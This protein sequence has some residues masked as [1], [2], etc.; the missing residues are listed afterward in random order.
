MKFP[1][2]DGKIISVKENQ[3]TARQCYAESQKISSTGQ[4]GKKDPPTVAHITHAEI[5]D[6]DLRSDSHDER[7]SPIDELDD[8][9]IGKLP[10][11][12]TK[13]SRQLNPN[14]RQQL[15][16]EILQNADLFAWSSADMP[17]IDANFICHRLAI[18]KEAK[19]VAQRK[20][21]V[22]G[23]RRE[24]IGSETQKLL[25]A[26]FICE[27]RYTTWLANVVLV[28]KNSGKWRMCIDYTDLN[29]AC[30]KDSYP[31]PSIDR[32]RLM[33]KVFHQ[34]IGRNME[35]YVDDMVV[36]TTSATDHASDLAEIFAQIRRHNMCLNLEK[37][38][39]G[40]QGGKF[41]GFMITN[42]GIETNPEKCKVIIQM[43]S[44]QTVK[45]VQRLAGR[46]VSQFGI[47]H[48]LV[49]NNGRQFIAQEFEDFL[50][51]LGIKHLPTSVEHPQTNGQAEAANKVIL[52][53]LK[54]WLGT[55]KDS[56]PTNFPAS[57]GRF[58]AL[59]SQPHKKRLTC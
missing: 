40:V 5:T 56:G 30:P 52:R 8:L 14:L 26:G 50:R 38:V 43:Q 16:A 27:V 15:K 47:P 51:K 4:P 18:H 29:K 41:L 42:R 35:V 28:K 58:I 7:P 21:K 20:R 25:N 17:G 24:A 54:K 19:P 45:E 46:L 9:Q 31:L 6:L 22:G 32:L 3:K 23:K 13:I 33:D 36:K 57:F 44:P 2:S 48:A 49:T 10:G 37:C 34:Q 1:G 12:C 53:E 55:P 11:Q 39:F 59:P